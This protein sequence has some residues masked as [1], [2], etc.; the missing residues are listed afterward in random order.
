[1]P[2]SQNKIEQL[3]NFK[4]RN[5]F[6]EREWEKRGFNPSISEVSYKLEQL[7][8]SIADDLI[9]AISNNVTDK[10]LKAIL[11][12]SLKK[13]KTSDFDTEER[14]FICEYFYE[15]SNIIK[16]NFK[17]NLD[18]W[19][20]GATLSTL[21][22][23][24]SLL[25]TVRIIDTKSQPCKKCEAVLETFIM[26][27]E[28]GIPDHSWQIVQCKNCKDYALISIGPDVKELRFGNYDLIEHLPKAEFTEE[29][30]EVRVE[31]LRFFRK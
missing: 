1:M 14:E 11:K 18:R 25:T 7:F 29:Q 31:Q 16:I 26:R 13:L 23:L 15:L 4:A 10:L 20:Y 8:N 2:L 19:L 5:K 28:E 12:D 27:K 21:V 22:N 3:I 24:K 9:T 17:N 6:S 30:A